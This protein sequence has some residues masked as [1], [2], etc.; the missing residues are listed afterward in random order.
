MELEPE[1]MLEGRWGPQPY[2]VRRLGREAFHVRLGRRGSDAFRVRYAF[3]PPPANPVNPVMRAWLMRAAASGDVE[4]LLTL[5]NDS[6]ERGN[7]E[8]ARER[9]V[10]AAERGNVHASL[11]L[12]VVELEAGNPETATAR[13][14]RAHSSD[15]DVSFL[16]GFAALEEGKEALAQSWWWTASQGGHVEALIILGMYAY[17][18]YDDIECSELWTMAAD[19]GHVDAMSLLARCA[20]LAGNGGLAMYWYDRAARALQTT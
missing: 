1:H 17:H 4:A 16:L 9:W 11:R 6:E 5:A 12:A 18:R 20:G 7:L 10:M 3:A 19:A 8:E 14:A 2:V 15:S 13:L